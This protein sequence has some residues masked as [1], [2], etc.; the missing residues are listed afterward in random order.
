MWF[1][2]ND[3]GKVIRFV[4]VCLRKGDQDVVDGA[5]RAGLARD[6]NLRVDVSAIDLS[7]GEIHD[8]RRCDCRAKP[9]PDIWIFPFAAPVEHLL[10]WLRLGERRH[11][12]R[13]RRDMG[14]DGGRNWNGRGR[15]GHGRPARRIVAPVMD[16]FG[17]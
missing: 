2:V 8:G 17:S 15:S 3:D 1:P 4:F 11:R 7:L 12:L 5:D 9:K 16:Q 14:R 6:N 13:G 10:H